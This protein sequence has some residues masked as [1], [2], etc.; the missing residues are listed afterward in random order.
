VS[1]PEFAES[2]VVFYISNLRN[3]TGASGELTGGLWWSWF[4]PLS[5]ISSSVPF[6]PGRNPSLV[7][8]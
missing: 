3:W 5:K 4:F 6:N 7:S 8:S 1:R 2:E